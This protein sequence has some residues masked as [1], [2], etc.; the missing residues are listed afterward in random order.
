[1]GCNNCSRFNPLNGKIES[2]HYQML[3]HYSFNELNQLISKNYQIKTIKI[4]NFKE[5]YN[6][7]IYTKSEFDNKYQ[8]I[9]EELTIEKEL[10]CKEINL[11][12]FSIANHENA[13]EDL[14]NIILMDDTY[15]MKKNNLENNLNK[16]LIFRTDMEN[17]LRKLIYYNTKFIFEICED[18]LMDY[19]DYKRFKKYF[20]D[21][22]INTLVIY[23][24]NE[25]DHFQFKNISSLS[26]AKKYFDIFDVK[27]LLENFPW[28]TKSLDIRL[29]LEFHANNK[30]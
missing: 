5:I 11:F 26:N 21:S 6:E 10:L 25:M 4:E 27:L 22:N 7:F 1:M 15:E 14:F 8:K 9:F 19:L 29:E 24:I 28:L 30:I 13:G 20:S 18:L 12:L 3:N 23:I 17:S 16:R 2:V